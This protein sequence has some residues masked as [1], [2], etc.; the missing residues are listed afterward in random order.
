M[1]DFLKK[2]IEFNN[3]ANSF[4]KMY[5]EINKFQSLFE[6]S[7]EDLIRLKNNYKLEILSLAYFANNEIIKRMDKYGWE[8]E[9]VFIVNEISSSKISIMN[10]WT[11]TITK[12]HILIGLFNLQNEYEDIKNNGPMY[13]IIENYI[14]NEKK[15]NRHFRS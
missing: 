10:A 5:I 7:E 14:E 8:L 9:H 3:L 13:A 2:G 4:G 15:I 12:L 11:K 1:F 6:K